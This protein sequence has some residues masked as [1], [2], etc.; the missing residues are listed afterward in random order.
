MLNSQSYC[1]DPNDISS[2]HVLVPW[3]NG[4]KLADPSSLQIEQISSRTVANILKKRL[5]IFFMDLDSKL[6]DVNEQTVTNCGFQ[7]T[8][9]A[10]GRTARDVAKKD[11]AEELIDNDRKVIQFHRPQVTDDIFDGLNNCLYNSL[12]LKFPWYGNDNRLIGVFGCGILLNVHS[13]ADSLMQI[14]QLGILNCALPGIKIDDSYLSKRENDCLYHYSR[15]KTTR[16]I[17]VI[18]NLSKRT[19]EHYLEN[20]KNKLGV[21]TKSEL[22][23]KILHFF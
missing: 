15:G 3:G 5:N 22:I 11:S 20:I 7:S 10:L 19:V 2:E 23:D 1:A 12:T 13:L 21:T 18:L 6:T 9:D 14:A 4:I 17:A 8:L 16:E